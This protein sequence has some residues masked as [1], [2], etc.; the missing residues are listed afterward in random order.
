MPRDFD[1][2]RARFP[3]E[4]PFRGREEKSPLGAVPSILWRAV[5]ILLNL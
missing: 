5:C 2:V 3:A 1:E 4:L